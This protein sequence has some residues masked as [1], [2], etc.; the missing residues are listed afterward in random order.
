MILAGASLCS[1]SVFADSLTH[2]HEAGR[3]A[4]RGQCGSDGIFG[5]SLP[6]ADNGLAEEPEKEARQ[7][8]VSI[9]GDTWSKGPICCDEAQLD[10][11]QSNLKRADLLIAACPACR[12]NFVNL[13]CTFT[14]SPDQS[15]FVNVTSVKEKAGK[16]LVT[17]LDHLVSDEYGSGFFES[18]KE[19]KF[20]A[21]NGRALDLIAPKVENHSQ[22]LKALGDK[23]PFG[24]PFQM[25]FPD[26]ERELQGM[27]PMDKEPWPCNTPDS[28]YH[29]QCVDCS[30]S[31]IK[32]PDVESSE[33][34]RIGSL[35]CFSFGI[36][37]AY[38]TFLLL[39]CVAN[40]AYRLTPARAS[41]PASTDNERANL[42]RGSSVADGENDSADV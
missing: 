21:T 25:N 7:K 37:V 9:C 30:E 40:V 14:C 41:S 26:S 4:L 33:P 34:C 36:I 10:A 29:C 42:L 6:C 17:E 22:F 38:A 8:L 3:C 32:L 16:L 31:C 19:V 27:Q 24:S 20:G 1:T 2:K 28:R 11:L 39:L 12:E 23:K 5:P 15:L 18:C 13:F 35:H